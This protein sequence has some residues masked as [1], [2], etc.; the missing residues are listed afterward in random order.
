MDVPAQLMSARTYVPARVVS[1]AFG[2]DV[3][4]DEMNNT[5]IISTK[6]ENKK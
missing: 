2:C 3:K 6:K 5:V 4:W 1:E